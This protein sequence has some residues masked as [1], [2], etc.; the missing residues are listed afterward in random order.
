[1]PRN[2][3][4]SKIK[5]I[6][7]W[8]DKYEYIIQLGKKLGN[9]KE[10]YKIEENLIEGCHSKVW[11]HINKSKG[12]IILKADSNTIITKGIIAILLYELSG[13]TPQE[14]LD[15]DFKIFEEIGLTEYLVSTRVKGL[16]SMITKIKN[17][18]KE[19]V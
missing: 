3:V 1:M 9:L 6:N 14:I 8:E 17:Y 16:H 19:N 4:L 5:K 2:N 11:I 7:D 15:Y 10:E 18:A 12:K 13:R